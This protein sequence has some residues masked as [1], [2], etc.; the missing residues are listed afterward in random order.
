[1][2][3]TESNLGQVFF[4]SDT[5]DITIDSYLHTP[6]DSGCAS[7]EVSGIA[8]DTCLNETDFIVDFPQYRYCS[9]DDDDVFDSLDCEAQSACT[10]DGDVLFSCQLVIQ[11][12]EDYDDLVKCAPNSLYI[13]FTLPDYD[14][15]AEIYGVIDGHFVTEVYGNG[16]DTLQVYF[17]TLDPLFMYD[18]EYLL[19]I[20]FTIP[21]TTD[22]DLEY[23]VYDQIGSSCT[24]NTITMYE[25]R[26]CLFST[27][28]TPP[29]QAI[30][31]FQC[32]VPFIA[33]GA[34]SCQVLTDGQCEAAGGFISGGLATTCD[35]T[36]CTKA[37][38][39]HCD[40]VPPNAC[41][42]SV[43]NVTMGLC[44]DAI[45]ENCPREENL[46]CT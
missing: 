40:C 28:A 10:E 18:P 13:N 43:C 9:C 42:M 21:S 35:T 39:S 2:L 5:T 30:E 23:Y 41:T 46:G 31:T 37:C 20:F 4:R 26:P 22:I 6:L 14:G 15:D 16:T 38:V 29:P 24:D 36:L 7:S 17:T 34:N 8:F 12:Y 33:P 1:L 19:R 11:A 25:E 32:C 44:V 45:K 3:V 27:E